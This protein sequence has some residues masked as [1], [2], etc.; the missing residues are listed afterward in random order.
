[1]SRV[2]KLSKTQIDVLKRMQIGWPLWFNTITKCAWQPCLFPPRTYWLRKDTFRK[3]GKLNYINAIDKRCKPI[4]FRLT[5]RALKL[6]EEL[7]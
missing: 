4:K 7:E 2:H 6:L 1:M 5:K 3:L